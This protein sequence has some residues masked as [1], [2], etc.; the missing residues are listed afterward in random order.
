MS[1]LR[2][3]VPAA[4]TVAVRPLTALAHPG[5]G[6]LPTG[7]APLHV[8]K[9][10][11]D[12]AGVIGHPRVTA[13]IAN[14]L[15]GANPP[16]SFLLTGPSGTGK[17]TLGRIIAAMVG[18][19]GAGGL[20]EVDAA[21]H[22]GVDN[23]RA[24]IGNAAFGSLSANS[25]KCIIVDEAHRLSKGAWDSMLLSIEEPPPHVWWVFCSTE[26]DKIP[27]T[28][29]TRCHSFDLKPV[30][31]EIIADYLDKVVASERLNIPQP[32]S[33]MAAIVAR[34]S[35]G[36][37]RQALVYL[38]TI[39]GVATKDE[40][41]KLIES[42]ENEDAAPAQLARMICLNRGFSW[43]AACTLLEKMRDES[44]ETIRLIVVN[45]ATKMLLETKGKDKAQSL[46]AILE[47]FRGPYNSSEGFGPLLLSIGGLAL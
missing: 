34:R 8:R 20:I 11:P 44:P 13:A 24:I 4:A 32:A 23:M 14:L 41:M 5:S 27:K 22:S 19:V 1:L 29:Q 30:Q 15:G 2:K 43:E 3:P 36:S 40:A 31:W 35:M 18:C 46:L 25:R 39:E 45:Y 12:L 16:H 17:T 42:A 28:I 33:E 37:V 9:R 38:S 47:N 21:R 26:P 6:A 7:G 10:P